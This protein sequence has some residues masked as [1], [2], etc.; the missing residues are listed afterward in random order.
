MV[1]AEYLC[2]NQN[3]AWWF[4]EQCKARVLVAKWVAYERAGIE[5][6]LSKV[7][8]RAQARDLS[9]SPFCTRRVVT[10]DDRSES[11]VVR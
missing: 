1:C 2:Q 10:V 11:R 9:R 6:T 4:M 7:H 5:G 8:R 3:F